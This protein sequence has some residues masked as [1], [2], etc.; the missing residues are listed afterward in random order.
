MR[1]GR[2]QHHRLSP[3]S[4]CRPRPF[5][6]T[7]G[8]W[9]GFRPPP[10]IPPVEPLPP[11]SPLPAATPALLPSPPAALVCGGV[12]DANF[13][14]CNATIGQAGCRAGDHHRDFRERDR[15]RHSLCTSES[16]PGR[17]QPAEWLH[18]RRSS[19][20]CIGLRVQHLGARMLAKASPCDITT[21]VGPISFSSN[22]LTVVASSSG[23]EPTYSST[24][25]S[26]TY[27]SGGTI[28][29]SKGQTCNLSNFGVGSS[30]GIEPSYSPV[31]KVQLTLRAD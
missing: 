30:S 3:P 19:D 27:T 25:N 23:I 11:T 24:T 5:R 14:N 26:P 22:D 18:Q 17:R 7:K 31:T 15:H 6:S 28:T 8:T 29:G 1:R 10:R 12:W 16:G 9:R 13:I 21:T 4:F 2:Q 20:T